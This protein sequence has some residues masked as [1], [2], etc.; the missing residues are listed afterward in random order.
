MTR[1]LAIL[2]EFGDQVYDFITE[3]VIDDCRYKRLRGKLLV[4]QDL[5]LDRTLDL[6]TTNWR[7]ASIKRFKYRTESM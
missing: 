5:N 7:P 4:E 3:Q 6:E 1:Q 2:C